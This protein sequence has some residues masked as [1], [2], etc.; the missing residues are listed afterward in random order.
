MVSRSQNWSLLESTIYTRLYVL[1]SRNRN[2]LLVCSSRISTWEKTLVLGFTMLFGRMANVILDYTNCSWTPLFNPGWTQ[3][4]MM[5]L[6]DQEVNST[7]VHS[8]ASH[9]LAL[10]FTNLIYRECNCRKFSIITP[11]VIG[12]D[13]WCH[14]TW[15]LRSYQMPWYLT[16]NSG[17]YWLNNQ[18][19]MLENSINCLLVWKGS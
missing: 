18:D 11:M 5:W 19:Y 17:N 2:S 8:Y 4:S 7:V 16:S 15:V 6:N 12:I 13:Q 14:L 1:D 9:R 10:T 3:L